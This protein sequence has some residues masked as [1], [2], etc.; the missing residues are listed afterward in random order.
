MED[1]LGPGDDGGQCGVVEHVGQ[2]RSFLLL[3]SPLYL[4]HSCRL[5]AFL[6]HLSASL[7]I[8]Q[9]AR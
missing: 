4:R 5:D 1:A 7:E 9:Q 2:A 8:N 6:D 3:D